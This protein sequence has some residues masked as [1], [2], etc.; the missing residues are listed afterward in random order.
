MTV[1]EVCF[2]KC[3]FFNFFFYA[4]LELSSANPLLTTY[5]MFL[6]SLID[7]RGFLPMDESV[8]TAGTDIELPTVAPKSEIN[9]V[10]GSPQLAFVLRNLPF[11]CLYSPKPTQSL[12]LPDGSLV[13][14]CSPNPASVCFLFSTITFCI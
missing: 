11:L 1:V 13:A 9:A 12:P 10:G 7:R 5:D 8:Q 3:F 4:A 2:S 14:C 6:T